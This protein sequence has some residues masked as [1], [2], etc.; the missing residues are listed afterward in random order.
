[1]KLRPIKKIATLTGVLTLAACQFSFANPALA[2]GTYSKSETTTQN[3]AQMESDEV[4]PTDSRARFDADNS[5]INKRDRSSAAVLPT[6]QGTSPEARN[7]AANIRNRISDSDTL[8][9]Y[10]KNV[11]IIALDNATVVL[12]GPVNS[13]AERTQIE[14]IARSAAP[15]WSIQNQIEVMKKAAS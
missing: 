14:Q 7:I 4:R 12:R 13:E 1:M 10:A 11:K 9:M 2:E 3:Q 6:D 5:A 8:S 15:Q